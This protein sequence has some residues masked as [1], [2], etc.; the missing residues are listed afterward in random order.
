MVQGKLREALEGAKRVEVIY[1]KTNDFSHPD[2]IWRIAEIYRC[3]GQYSVAEQY[4]KESIEKCL[5]PAPGLE[6]HEKLNEL[7]EGRA[8][9]FRFGYASALYKMGNLAG[10]RAQIE[11]ALSC[12]GAENL[13]TT[14]ASVFAQ[15]AIVAARQNRME[16][17]DEYYK[18]A[19]TRYEKYGRDNK[20]EAFDEFELLGE[21]AMIRD[22][23]EESETMY[24]KSLALSKEV[25]L[26]NSVLMMLTLEGYAELLR[27]MH[28]EQD[29]IQIQQ[30]FEEI[31]KHAT[32]EL[33]PT[34]SSK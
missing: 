33:L 25:G 34:I 16:K 19:T 24:K 14:S 28:R 7:A 30:R 32:E 1:R 8:A 26:E 17:A 13:K 21:Y 6:G 15:A 12:M 4:H 3:G 5:I 31:L 10:A 11:K 20:L 29:A 9:V 27:K 22:R 23:F 2:S 18:E